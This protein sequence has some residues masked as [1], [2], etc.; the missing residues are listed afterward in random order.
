M[1][2]IPLLLPWGLIL[3]KFKILDGIFQLG[4]HQAQVL[5]ANQAGRESTQSASPGI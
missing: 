3:Q 2:G 4:D 5:K 1:M